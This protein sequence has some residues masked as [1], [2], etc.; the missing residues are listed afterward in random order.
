M[1]EILT[2]ISV[3][4]VFLI[5]LFE[6]A[7]KRAEDLLA[8]GTPDSAKKEERAKLKKE[9]D[10]SIGS[11]VFLFIY[12]VTT[13]IGNVIELFKIDSLNYCNILFTLI[14]I[15]ILVFAVLEINEIIKMC[16][17]KKELCKN[18]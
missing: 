5:V 16:N 13:L 8:N 3:F 15:G 11:F 12:S 2:S 9:I 7:Y 6:L 17:R 18:N 1:N 10:I 4:L 14:T